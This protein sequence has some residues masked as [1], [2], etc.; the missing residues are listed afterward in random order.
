MALSIYFQGQK[1]H[2]ANS[3]KHVKISK[4]QN[5]SWDSKKHIHVHHPNQMHFHV[6][7]YDL[8]HCIIEP[9][10]QCVFIASACSWYS[11]NL[12]P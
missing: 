9:M 4:H 1:H 6:I 2:K 10:H 3:N 5:K 12:K 8:P 11:N 7:I